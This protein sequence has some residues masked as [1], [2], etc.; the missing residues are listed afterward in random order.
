V[1][2]PVD[3]VIA[4]RAGMDRGFRRGL[5]LSGGGHLLLVLS[6]GIASFVASRRPQIVIADGF[7]DPIPRGGRGVQS[8]E[9]PAPAQ[10]PQPA[11]PVT[12]AP[13]PPKPE[14]L[15]P[16]K[17]EPRQG[18]PDPSEKEKKGRKAK[19]T[20]PP[21]FAAG[22]PGGTGTSAKT[23]GME[24]APAG[25]GVPYGTELTSDWYMATV[26]QRIWAL[27]VQ[28]IK[29]GMQQ[30]AIIEFTIQAD[31]S[32]ADPKV[33]QSSGA[34]MLD[35]AAQRA[36]FSAGPFGPL[37]KNYGTNQISIRATFKPS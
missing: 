35:L 4:D 14:I 17:E 23:P 34:S 6:V 10:A 16:P 31:G 26:Q 25:I 24:W 11:P 5:V 21:R 30:P 27:W 12:A 33:V 36:I 7:A 22:M 19:E 20:P 37:P 3:R 28:Q 8:A 1:N 13:Q 18:L 29:A 32:V 2:D 9:R 15:K